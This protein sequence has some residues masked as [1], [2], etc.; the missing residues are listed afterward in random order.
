MED[1]VEEDE[2]MGDEISD[3]EAA[4][5]LEREREPAAGP[6]KKLVECSIPS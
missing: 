1:E 3:E 2:T 4:Q 5:N 6:N